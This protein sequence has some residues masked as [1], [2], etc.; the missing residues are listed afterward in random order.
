MSH[1][2][3]LNA[4]ILSARILTTSLYQAIHT[5]EATITNFSARKATISL[6]YNPLQIA[7]THAAHWFDSNSITPNAKKSQLIVFT[8]QE[9]IISIPLRLHGTHIEELETN[10]TV[11]GALQSTPEDQQAG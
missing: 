2:F 11:W 8:L 4:S 3:I 7:V 10:K 6:I 1:K 9:S 5:K